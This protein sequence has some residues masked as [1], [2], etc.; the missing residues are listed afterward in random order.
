MSGYSGGLGY[1]PF[2]GS[3]GTS[4]STNATVATTTNINLSSAPASIDGYNSLVANVSTVLVKNQTPDTGNGNPNDGLYLWTGTGNPMTRLSGYTDWNSFV[5]L[6][7]IVL[8]GTINHDTVWDS[9]ATSGGTLGTTDLL[10]INTG[11]STPFPAN[12]KQVATNGID[13]TNINLTFNGASQQLTSGGLI[14][15]FPG[16][17]NA[18]TLSLNN[19]IL[20]GSG[21]NCI[22]LSTSNTVTVNNND[23]IVFKN[24]TFG[25]SS[26]FP[27]CFDLNGLNN[28][29]LVFE[30][31]TFTSP[32]ILT[33]FA[34]RFIDIGMTMYLQNC[35]SDFQLFFSSSTSTNTSVYIDSC[36]GSGNSL[37]PIQM[38]ATTAGNLFIEARN[39]K[40]EIASHGGGILKLISC[41]YN[42]A[43]S[44]AV[45]SANNY[46]YICGGTSF[47]IVSGGYNP[48]IKT[49]NCDG[50]IVNTDMGNVRSS[51]LNG[52]IPITG[53]NNNNRISNMDTNFNPSDS[54]ILM[55][56]SGGNRT[57]ILYLLGGHPS[58]VNVSNLLAMV[59]K[60]DP[61][62]NTLTI[63]VSSGDN[64]QNGTS[65]TSFVTTTQ[66][67]CNT[68]LPNTNSNAWYRISG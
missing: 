26:S 60:T 14:G 10:F 55:D 19:I 4:H 9:T 37:F 21:A 63:V 5:G 56:C 33:N 42:V 38:T 34:A 62:E 50:E 65:S 64:M 46:L 67:V 29:N 54:L 52:Y 41:E 22:I 48:I 1:I 6:S 30:N 68:F 31:C 13:G 53:F 7:V 18:P 16:T 51:T 20:N 44:I 23:N 45:K 40:I 11:G 57:V 49:G 17:Y 3:S 2:G 27:I 8:N 66:D 47:S 25:G 61:S 36:S 28:I 15:G 12:Y 35:S 39:S 43:S 59:I 58:T 24:F 32:N